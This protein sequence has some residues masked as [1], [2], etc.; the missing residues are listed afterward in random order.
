[1][2]NHHS[3]NIRNVFIQEVK[4]FTNKAKTI[5]GVLKIAVIGSLSTSKANP[6][7]IDMLLTIDDDM[8][9]SRLAKI[10]RQMNGHVQAYNHNAEVFLSNRK[11]QYIG[12]ICHWKDCGPG[13]RKSCDAMHCGLRKYLHD[14][15]C[16]VCLDSSLINNPPI[17]L[18]PEVKMSGEIPDDLIKEIFDDKN[19]DF[20]IK[21][22]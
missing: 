11:D 12:R 9:L 18:W 4:I 15:L 22:G 10:T 20:T 16:S 3:T 13:I 8:D 6:K 2:I 21:G 1:M 7:D 14:D 19:I 5:P 17:V